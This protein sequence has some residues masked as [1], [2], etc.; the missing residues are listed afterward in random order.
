MK[1][2]WV[3][4]LVVAIGCA[5]GYRRSDDSPSSTAS[6]ASDASGQTAV[7]PEQQEARSKQLIRNR[8]GKI[9]LLAWPQLNLASIKEKLSAE[10]ITETV[11]RPGPVEV[12]MISGGSLR[13]QW[14]DDPDQLRISTSI[15]LEGTSEAGMMIQ[16]GVRDEMVKTGKARSV[17]LGVPGVRAYV[18][19]PPA[20]EL[21]VFTADR[22]LVVDASVRGG[23]ESTDALI[24]RVQVSVARSIFNI[25]DPK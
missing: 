11:G 7:T 23:S 10:M 4:G 22:I 6:S 19:R 13:Y 2:A 17:D 8:Y 14:T 24:H 9:E 15:L 18:T 12:E 25:F 1:R 20:G 3:L 16:V 5:D 21:T